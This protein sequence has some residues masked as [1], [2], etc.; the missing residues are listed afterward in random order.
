MGQYK[1]KAPG[2]GR[3]MLKYRNKRNNDSNHNLKSILTFVQNGNGQYQGK[4]DDGLSKNC[5]QRSRTV[6]YQE[7]IQPIK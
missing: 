7:S 5:L 2:T 1:E 6:N 3:H 4:G